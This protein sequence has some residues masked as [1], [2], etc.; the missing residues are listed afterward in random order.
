MTKKVKKKRIFGLKNTKNGRL[1]KKR[2]FLIW[3]PQKPEP[4][5]RSTDDG[6]P[7]SWFKLRNGKRSIARMKL[8]ALLVVLACVI[9]TKDNIKIAIFGLNKAYNASVLIKRTCLNSL[10]GNPN[11][12][13]YFSFEV[14]IIGAVRKSD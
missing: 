5:V 2:R 12:G 4:S 13:F 6:H 11:T 3:G 9:Q 14:K 10:Q 1:L 8:V 7:N